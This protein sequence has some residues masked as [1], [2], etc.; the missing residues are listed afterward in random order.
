[1]NRNRLIDIKNKLLLGEGGCRG[2][3]HIRGGED[4]DLGIS[5]CKLLCTEWVNKVL[6]CSMGNYIQYSAIIIVKRI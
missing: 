4:W 3:R 5:R 2:G 1:M 6:L